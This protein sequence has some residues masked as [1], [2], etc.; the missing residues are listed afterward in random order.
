MY[1]LNAYALKYTKKTHNKKLVDLITENVYNSIVCITIA[2]NITSLKKLFR[3]WYSINVFNYLPTS[4]NKKW[5]AKANFR[6]IVVYNEFI[7]STYIIKK[8]TSNFH[9]K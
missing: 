2:Q 8:N 9:S 7:I 4:K 5:Y 6:K 3:L 1:I